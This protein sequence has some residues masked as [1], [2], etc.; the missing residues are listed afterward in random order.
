MGLTLAMDGHDSV[1]ASIPKTTIAAKDSGLEKSA[2][3]SVNSPLAQE[4]E[5]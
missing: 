3:S 5:Q 4:Q 1:A 2:T